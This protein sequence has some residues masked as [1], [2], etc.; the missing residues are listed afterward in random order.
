MP[1]R[2][3]DNDAILAAFLDQTDAGARDR[4]LQ[5]LLARHVGP[6][7]E[8]MIRAELER[9]DEPV[10]LETATDLAA[11]VSLRLI[12]KLQRLAADPRDAPIDRFHDYVRTVAHNVLHDHEKRTN[13]WRGRLGHRVRY[14]LTRTPALALWGP[15]PVRCGFVEWV[16]RTDVREVARPLEV[17]PGAVDDVRRL[18]ALIV[19]QLRRAGGPVEVRALVG[20]LGEVAAAPGRPFDPETVLAARGEA[21]DPLRLLADRQYLERLWGEIVELPLRQRIALLLQLRL[22]DGESVAHLLPVV[23]IAD[24]RMLAT[25]IGMSVEQLLALWNDLPLGD[26]QIAERLG[27]ERQQVINLRKSARERLA[28]RMRR[29]G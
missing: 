19:H 5:D 27:V 20:A 6:R 29:S 1:E 10:D 2:I 8:K 3:R 13:P 18:R 4:A 7:V 21:A 15:E 12:G 25:T 26:Q 28:R 17:P 23:G 24:V 16:G 14:V 11:E 22:D 9:D